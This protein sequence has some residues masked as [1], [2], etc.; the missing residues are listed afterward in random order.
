MRGEIIG[1]RSFVF[2]FKWGKKRTYF[3][4]GCD[5]L[6]LCCA[7]RPA[8]RGRKHFLSHSCTTFICRPAPPA[9][10]EKYFKFLSHLAA[11]GYSC[12]RNECEGCS[13]RFSENTIT[14]KKKKNRPGKKNKRFL[15]IYAQSDVHRLLLGDV[16]SVLLLVIGVCFIFPGAWRR[17]LSQSTTQGSGQKAK[18]QGEGERGGVREE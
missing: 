13:Q 15:C 8:A 1:S 14:K 6:P 3:T 10:E 16:F 2:V 4:S 7:S 18:P 9:N 11:V 12:T 17:I 5:Q